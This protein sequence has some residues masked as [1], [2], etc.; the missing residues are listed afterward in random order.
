MALKGVKIVEL[1]G[2][3]PVPFCGLI[4]ADFGA[5][6][7][8]V[9]RAGASNA[10]QLC[11]G[12]RSIALD[13]KKK[14]AI[15]VLLTLISHSD[16]LLDPFRPGVLEKLGVGP[17]VLHSINPKL[18]VARLTGFGQTGSDIA[19][20]LCLFFLSFSQ[21]CSGRAFQTCRWS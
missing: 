6:V 16:I 12:K 1:A 19:A 21:S 4:L 10:D 11:R 13:L 5:D 20:R 9:D 8:R 14:E 3:A 2:L 17:D 7:I 18:I 15:D